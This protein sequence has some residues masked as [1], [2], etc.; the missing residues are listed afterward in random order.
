MSPKTFEN[1]PHR[2][3]GGEV[4]PF[5]KI[6]NHFLFFYLKASIIEKKDKT[7]ESKKVQPLDA[8]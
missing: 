6:P 1:V 7:R 5:G 2:A 4:P 3:K 8:C